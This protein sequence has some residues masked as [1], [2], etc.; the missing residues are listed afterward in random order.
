MALALDK[1]TERCHSL[2]PVVGLRLPC[3]SGQRLECGNTIW[4]QAPGS[5]SHTSCVGKRIKLSAL[6]VIDTISHVIASSPATHI[7]SLMWP[8]MWRCGTRAWPNDTHLQSDTGDPCER[9]PDP[10]PMLDHVAASRLSL[11]PNA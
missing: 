10:R 1:Q 11:I 8:S 7:P 4:I 9:W 2:G 6:G 3:P 5:S